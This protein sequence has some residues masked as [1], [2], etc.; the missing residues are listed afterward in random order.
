MVDIMKDMEEFLELTGLSQE[1]FQDVLALG[2][3][4]FNTENGD[5]PAYTDSDIYKARKLVRICT[6][7]ELP[8]VGGTIIVD[9]LE[10]IALLEERVKVLQEGR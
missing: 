6:D 5:E 7:F 4:E 8:I 2:W 9:L 1:H 3:L 10:R